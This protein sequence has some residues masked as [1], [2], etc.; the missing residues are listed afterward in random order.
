MSGFQNNPFT[1]KIE[2]AKTKAD[3]H[4]IFKKQFVNTSGVTFKGGF[5]SDG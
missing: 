4:L 5:V 2:N 3:I 1:E